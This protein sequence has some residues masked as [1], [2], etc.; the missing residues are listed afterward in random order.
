MR[1]RIIEKYSVCVFVYLFTISLLSS[2]SSNFKDN[3]YLGKEEINL[4]LTRSVYK[5]CTLHRL[6]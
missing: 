3:S 6:Y 5:M 2:L 4:L 1:N